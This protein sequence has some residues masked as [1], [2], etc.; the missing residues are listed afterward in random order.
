M[1]E[2]KV[3]KAVRQREEVLKLLEGC[4]LE[5]CEGEDNSWRVK[6]NFIMFSLQAERALFTYFNK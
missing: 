4:F 2:N 1:N 5:Y 6:H 3:Q